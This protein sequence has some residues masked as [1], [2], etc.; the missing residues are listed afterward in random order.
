[1]GRKKDQAPVLAPTNIEGGGSVFQKRLPAWRRL[2]YLF[3]S[4]E[5][6]NEGRPEIF[7]RRSRIVYPKEA[8]F[9]LL[10]G[11]RREK[12]KKRGNPY[13]A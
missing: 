12:K 10:N 6:R 7:V 4:G 3:F 1:L 8:A 2:R 9:L 5:G 11:G 13:G